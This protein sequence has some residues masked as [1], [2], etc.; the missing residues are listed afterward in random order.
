[1][2]FQSRKVPLRSHPFTLT[3]SKGDST[4]SNVMWFLFMATIFPRWGPP[5]KDGD[6]LLFISI[7]DLKNKFSTY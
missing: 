3:I 2:T 4:N 5:T 6:Q 1:M 7:R